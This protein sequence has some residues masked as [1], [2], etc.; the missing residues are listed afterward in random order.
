MNFDAEYYPYPSRRS[1]V[2]ANR[3]MVAT[4]Q[5]LAAQAGL[6]ILRQGGNAIDAAVATAACL[7]VV[8]PTSNGIGGDAFALV[9]TRDKLHGL[10][11]SGPAPMAL[12]PDILRQKGFK[13]MPSNGWLPVTVPGTPSAWAELIRRFGSLSLKD[14]LAPAIEYAENGFPVSPVISRQWRLGFTRFSAATGPEYRSW[15]DTFAPQERPPVA[16]EIWRSPA[17]AATLR[18]L[19]ASDCRE[20]YQGDLA[21]RIDVFCQRT[22]RMAPSVRSC[23]IQAGMGGTDPYSLSRC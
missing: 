11:A 12:T 18:L 3:G 9:W 7:T 15:F 6:A 4:S 13:E 5:A 2:F 19:A 22:W 23:R 16:G 20:F 1:M 10:N 17:H 21:A 14:V 8:E